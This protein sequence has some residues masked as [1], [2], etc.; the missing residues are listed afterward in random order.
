MWRPLSQVTTKNPI[1]WTNSCKFRPKSQFLS[2]LLVYF[3]FCSSFFLKDAIYVGFLLV[4]FVM[5]FPGLYSGFSIFLLLCIVLFHASSRDVICGIQVTE[6][7]ISI[8][9]RRKIFKS[10]NIVLEREKHSVFKLTEMLFFYSIW[11]HHTIILDV[12]FLYIP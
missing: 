9:S 8:S 5:W 6:G 11:P 1:C 4:S 7:I 10:F 2:F 3:L 12:N